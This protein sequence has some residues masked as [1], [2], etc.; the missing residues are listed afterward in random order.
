MTF[1]W[2]MGMAEIIYLVAALLYMVFSLASKKIIRTLAI[3]TTW[4]GFIFHTTLLVMRI[5][6]TGHPPLTNMYETLILFSWFLV[7][8]ALIVERRYDIKI[9]GAFTLPLVFLMLAST[10]LISSQVDPI[11]P[12]LKSNWLLAHVLTCFVGYASFA[13]AFVTSV[14]Y[15]CFKAYL[16]IIPGSQMLNEERLD[17]LDDLTYSIVNFGFPFLTLGIITGSIW[18]DVC[19]GTYWNW[20]PKET[21]AF[22]SWL[23]YGAYL[24]MRYIRNWKGTW[25][26]GASV[27]AFVAILFTYFGVNNLF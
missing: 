18:A 23:I 2:C 13:V 9:L 6:E 25:N 3:V 12:A 20:D 26:A 21:W 22:V 16:K 1:S 7:I 19:W 5:A 17:F 11:L 4:C 27:V 10:S 24:H 15:L 14:M 8:C